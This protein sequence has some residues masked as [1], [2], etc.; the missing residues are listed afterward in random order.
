MGSKVSNKE[1]RSLEVRANGECAGHGWAGAPGPFLQG[2]ASFSKAHFQ[3]QSSIQA[4]TQVTPSPK[5]PSGL[6]SPI[7]LL[8]CLSSVA[9]NT[10]VWLQASFQVR[11]P[12]LQR[13]RQLAL[14]PLVGL[15]QK[16]GSISSQQPDN[17]KNFSLQAPMGQDYIKGFL[18]FNSKPSMQCLVQ[19]DLNQM[20]DVCLTPFKIRTHT[21]GHLGFVEK[22]MDNECREQDGVRPPGDDGS[23]RLAMMQG[24]ASSRFQCL[25]ETPPPFHLNASQPI[26]IIN[27][28]QE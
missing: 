25:S 12:Y 17:E 7:S 27:S 5:R 15:Q 19:G 6:L 26:I 1:W 9:C 3:K 21:R 23:C 11:L 13:D 10:Y 2:Q 24:V 16:D 22:R 20:H 28:N 8:T 14:Q 18:M 4:L